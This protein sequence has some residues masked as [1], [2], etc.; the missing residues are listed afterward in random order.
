[1]VP[2][3]ELVQFYKGELTEN[4]LL[5]KAATLAAQRDMLLKSKLPAGIVNARVKPLSRELH[6]LTKRV[7]R[8]PVGGMGSEMEEGDDDD[9]DDGLITGPMEQWMKKMIKGTPSKKEIKKEIEKEIKKEVK[10]EKQASSKA[11]TSGKVITPFSPRFS[12]RQRRKAL[13]QQ[14]EESKKKRRQT[15]V[16]RLKSIPGWRIWDKPVKRKLK[17]DFDE[18]GQ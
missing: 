15:E 4:A 3:K 11:S 1:M 13:E 10:K 8:G 14:V 6:H 18:D 17:D 9:E 2:P 5:N 16:E 7:R 12:F